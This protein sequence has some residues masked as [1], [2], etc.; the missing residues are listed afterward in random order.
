[1]NTE[2]ATFLKLTAAV[3]MVEGELLAGDRRRTGGGCGGAAPA[4]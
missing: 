2:A 4:P 3:Y 1:M